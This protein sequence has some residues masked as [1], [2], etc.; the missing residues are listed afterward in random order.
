MTTGEKIA[1]CR[2]K[3]GY[4]Q[5]RLAEEMGVTRQAVSRWESDLAFPETDTLI[6]LSKLFG[7]ST[8]W[9]LNYNSEEPL[10]DPEA[11]APVPTDG[12][13]ETERGVFDLKTFHYEY[14]S[15]AHIGKIPLVHVNIGFG[16]VAKGIVSVGLCSVGV[17]SLGLISLGIV[18][19]G[20]LALGFLAL[21]SVAAGI[22]AAGGVGLG[23][24]A[25]GGLAVGLFSM[26][27]CAVGL[28]ACGGYASGYYVAIGDVAVG[29]VAVGKTRANGSVLSVSADQIKLMRDIVYEKLEEIPKFWSVF[30][31][32]SRGLI[33]G[34]TD[35]L[36]IVVKV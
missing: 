11:D 33:E 24:I 12:K 29:G 3:L 36:N 17:I 34:M 7:C 9:L 2:K 22:L 28:F 21:G 32:W 6:R 18:A 1:D 20:V 23:V 26:G 35:S 15:R 19:I 13:E 8:D 14:V 16:R 5:V 30:V 4:T 25:L 31:S 10:R 27:G